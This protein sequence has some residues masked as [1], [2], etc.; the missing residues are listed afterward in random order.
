MQ[1]QP[2]Q[3]SEEGT[4]AGGERRGGSATRAGEPETGQPGEAPMP[5]GKAE[6]S[7]ATATGGSPQSPRDR[8]TDAAALA[9]ALARLL[10]AF[11]SPG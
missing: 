5:G 11:S 2:R 1:E 10:L 6:L 8:Q 3:S 9:F 7:T 4:R